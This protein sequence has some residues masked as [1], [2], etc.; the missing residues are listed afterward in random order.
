[1]QLQHGEHSDPKALS[2][3]SSG[4]VGLNGK[5]SELCLD[6]ICNFV[7]LQKLR[8]QREANLARKEE[9]RKKSLITQKISNPATLK[10]M[11]KSKKQRKKLMTADTLKSV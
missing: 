10:R 1:M 6:L 3:I 9:N 7:L 4:L 8:Q 5:N 11:M 2:S